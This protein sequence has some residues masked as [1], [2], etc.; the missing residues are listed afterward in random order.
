MFLARVEVF[1]VIAGQVEWTVGG[2]TH[3]MGPGSLVYI[4]PDTVHSVKV[5]GNQDYRELMIY[6]PGGYED[7][8]YREK[9][10]TLQQQEQ[11]DIKKKLRELGDFNP[12]KSPA[13]K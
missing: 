4:P 9:E 2:E 11:P 7:N 8:I 1:H 6:N 12:A 13:K 3:L 10:Y 5:V